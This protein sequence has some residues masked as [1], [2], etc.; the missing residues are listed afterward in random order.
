[1]MHEKETYNSI[2]GLLMRCIKATKIAAIFVSFLLLFS[3]QAWAIRWDFTSSVEGWTGRNTTVRHSS[4]GNGR[5]YMDTYGNDP[6]MVSPNLSLSASSNS[7]IKMYIWTYCSNRNCTVYFK[8]SGSSTVF[9]GGSVYMN[10][11]S[12]GGTYEV[13]MSGNSNWT[14]TITQLRIDPADSCGSVSSPGFV[15]FDWIETTLVPTPDLIVQN[16]NTS[17]TSIEAG[18]T[19]YASCTVRN[20][21]SGSA[22]SSYLRYYLSSNTTY[23]TSDTELGYDPVGSLSGGG[24]SSESAT[25]TIPPSTS[26]G[27]WYILFRADADNQVTE[28]DEIN[29]VAYRQ[30]TVNEPSPNPPNLLSPTNYSIFSN[31]SSI[32]FQWTSVSGAV[33]YELEIDD[34]FATS[35]GFKYYITA[36][37]ANKTISN[38]VW[39]GNNIYYWRVRAKN[40]SGVWGSPQSTYWQFIYDSPP[41]AP[42]FTH[43]QPDAQITIGESETFSWDSP[44]DSVNRYWFRVVRGS[45]PDGETVEDYPSVVAPTTSQLIQFTDPKWT[46]GTYTCWVKAIKSN[47]DPAHYSDTTYESTI[48]W[49]PYDAMQFTLLEAIPDIP[50]NVNAVQ[51]PDGI[52]ITWD[53]VSGVSGSEPYKI[54]WG[55]DSSVDENNKAGIFVTNQTIYDHTPLDS[56]VTYYYRV[57]A[58]NG[59]TCSILSDTTNAQAPNADLT[60]SLQ[61]IPNN[62]NA[63]RGTTFPI[64]CTVMR[65]GGL[66]R[67]DSDY[68]RVY[69]YMNQSTDH[70]TV[71]P[72]HLV[73]GEAGT[74]SFD[75]PN[76]SL[77]D[78]TEAATHDILVPV[79]IEGP[80]YIHVKVDGPDHWGES[81]ENNNWAISSNTVVVWR[82]EVPN[83]DSDNGILART[84]DDSKVYWIS[85]Y[86]KKWPLIGIASDPGYP[87]VQLGYTDADV[88]WYRSGALDGLEIATEIVND[89]DN[90]FVYRRQGSEP[91]DST[92]FIVRNGVSDWFFN[93]ET[94]INSE[95]GTEDVYWAT[96][97]GFEWI[98]SVYPPGQLIGLQPR[99][100]V[101]PDKLLF[102]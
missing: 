54:Y 10:Y 17:P 100:R 1:M 96:D 97:A 91:E 23:G 48:G 19:T 51:I 31:P 13:D 67:P 88:H 12:S 85:K 42:S 70:S 5:L 44:Q 56:G 47:P 50:Q 7:L 41:D 78:G 58:C 38:P 30:I 62:S 35:D 80:Y 90:K 102:Q 61:T 2:K 20:Q 21:G 77:D 43:P 15:A 36:P 87:V 99:I 64:T 49:G 73:L 98:Q 79:T 39:R 28:S 57:K 53:A 71:T 16:Q 6:G 92:V 69:V 89:N 101:M 84:W 11:G 68:V 81:D 82:D 66:L 27:T 86:S 45:N 34:N 40:S 9:Y 95:F 83:I 72:E 3:A 74:S 93:W 8:R 59:D 55:N 29:N 14:G 4:D 24:T 46:A 75:F 26:A 25:L 94:F 18:S 65:T 33:E 63:R 60:I 37:T 76:A 22:G 32:T 52:R